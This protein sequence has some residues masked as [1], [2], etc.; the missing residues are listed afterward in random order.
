MG[1]EE[2]LTFRAAQAINPRLRQVSVGG[3]LTASNPKLGGLVQL[4]RRSNPPIG[5]LIGDVALIDDRR[6]ENTELDARPQAPDLS[7]LRNDSLT[8]ILGRGCS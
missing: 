3:I 7:L 6:V 8:N 5:C 4:G 1:F 2:P